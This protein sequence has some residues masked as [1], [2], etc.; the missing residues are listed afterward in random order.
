MAEQSGEVMVRSSA[1]GLP[2]SQPAIRVSA[3]PAGVGKVSGETMHDI[4][5]CDICIAYDKMIFWMKIHVV[6]TLAGL[7]IEALYIAKDSGSS[8]LL[9]TVLLDCFSGHDYYYIIRLLMPVPNSQHT[10]LHL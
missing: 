4:S 7:M 6:S 9:N 3:G 2:M 10:T 8:V 5:L 1:A